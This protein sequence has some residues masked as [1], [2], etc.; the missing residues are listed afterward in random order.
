MM[1]SNVREIAW[2]MSIIDDLGTNYK[3]ESA[4]QQMF[5]NQQNAIGNV[6]FG[7]SGIS[8]GAGYKSLISTNSN[9]AE[10][11]IPSLISFGIDAN[12]VRNGISSAP[13]TNYSTPSPNFNL[14]TKDNTNVVLP[15]IRLWLSKIREYSIS[16]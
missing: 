16:W 4:L 12:S 14:Q 2:I 5:P 9:N 10:K 7:L 1:R 3:G 8:V 11:F 13:N 15:I 6:K